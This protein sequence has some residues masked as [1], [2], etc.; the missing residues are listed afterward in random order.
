MKKTYIARGMLEWHL[1]LR[2]GNAM[3]PVAFT[4]GSM[5]ANGIIG[6]KF[7]T[8]NPALQKMIEASEFYRKHRICILS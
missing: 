8:D 2:A 6:A 4:G 3:I 7:T 5:G 1:L